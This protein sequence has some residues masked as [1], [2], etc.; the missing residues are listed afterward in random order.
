MNG[1]EEIIVKILLARVFIRMRDGTKR[2]LILFS[3]GSLVF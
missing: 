3:L 2:N 1:M